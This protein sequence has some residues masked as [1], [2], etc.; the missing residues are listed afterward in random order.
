M[1]GLWY[2]KQVGRWEGHGTPRDRPHHRWLWRRPRLP[3]SRYGEGAQG[4]GRPPVSECIQACKGLVQAMVFSPYLPPH[5][6]HHCCAT[7]KLGAHWSP[8]RHCNATS[9]CG[10]PPPSCRGAAQGQHRNKGMG[11][12]PSKI[13]THNY[14]GKCIRRPK[15][16]SSPNLITP[17]LLQ[18]A[19]HNHATIGFSPDI[20]RAQYLPPGVPLPSPPPGPHPGNPR[21]GRSHRNVPPP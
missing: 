13:P 10:S 15:H 8:E 1:R 5:N 6:P 3:P 21:T 20:R 7:R 2:D 17:P 18:Y 12:P 19:H 16:S 14:V 4:G 11:L 9:K